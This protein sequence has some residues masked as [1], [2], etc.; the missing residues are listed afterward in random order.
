[1][2]TDE[3]QH[4]Q[5]REQTMLRSLEQLGSSASSLAHEIKNPISAV[6]LALRAV[7]SALGE[8]EQSVLRDLV[9]RMRN[10]ELGIRR[11][12]G[13]VQPL[14]AHPEPCQLEPIIRAAWG[15]AGPAGPEFELHGAANCPAVS[16]DSELL[17]EALTHLFRNAREAIEAHGRVSVRLR[18]SALNQVEVQISDDG[19]GVAS[20]VAGRLFEPFVTT[21]VDGAGMGLAICRKILEAHGGT[22]ALGDATGGGAQFDLCLPAAD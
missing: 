20:E 2:G 13:F 19:P 6:H 17:G 18:T 4:V 5:S 7:A 11:V 14:V 12:I 10:V 16:A 9:G 15:Q 8:D 3:S 1:M 21:K 22:I